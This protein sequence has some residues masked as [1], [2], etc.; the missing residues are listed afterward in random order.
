MFK[1][2][3]FIL[4]DILPNYKMPEKQNILQVFVSI[5]IKWDFEMVKL[6][7]SIFISNRFA[8]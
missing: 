1:Y 5:F 4:L 3:K 6:I 7:I 2:G 8:I